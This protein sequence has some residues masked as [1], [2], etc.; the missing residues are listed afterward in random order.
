MN[1]PLT[2]SEAHLLQ[3]GLLPGRVQDKL[4]EGRLGRGLKGPQGL[5]G[6]LD[7]RRS[8]VRGE[9]AAQVNVLTVHVQVV[10][11]RSQ[12]QRT[13]QVEQEVTLG[14]TGS[15]AVMVKTKVVL[16]YWDPLMEINEPA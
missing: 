8:E 6:F 15:R 7:P 9:T 1:A 3:Q 4:I 14:Q 13:Q 11:R 5:A 12:G 10:Y 16:Q 2:S